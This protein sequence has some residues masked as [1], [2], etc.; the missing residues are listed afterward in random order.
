MDNRVKPVIPARIFKI[1]EWHL[2]V[3]TMRKPCPLRADALI[4]TNNNKVMAIDGSMM[5]IIGRTGVEAGP[6][7]LKEYWPEVIT[8]INDAYI[9]MQDHGS[10]VF[11]Q[12]RYASYYN[13]KL[14]GEGPTDIAALG[15]PRHMTS[16]DAV[17]TWT[18]NRKTYFFKGSNYWRYNEAYRRFD[19]G[20]PRSIKRNWRGLPDHVDTAFIAPNHHMY[21]VKNGLIYK[22]GYHTAKVKYR[23]PKRLFDSCYEFF[24]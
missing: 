19:H 24:M 17:S 5:Y 12:G 9:R 15:L 20:Y 22:M 23:Y 4:R 3:F 11:F 18:G 10:V 1:R 14:L 6:M 13:D 21:F 7:P 8:P 16:F 2:P